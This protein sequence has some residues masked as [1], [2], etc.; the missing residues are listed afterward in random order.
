[1]R[2][3]SKLYIHNKYIIEKWINHCHLVIDEKNLHK[4]G[5]TGE[6]SLV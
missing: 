6:V 4:I 2:K 1:M 5:P 3:I